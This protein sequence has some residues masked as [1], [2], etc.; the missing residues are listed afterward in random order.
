[1]STP[2]IVHH[3]LDCRAR[4]LGPRPR[5]VTPLPVTAS[6]S[7]GLGDLDAALAARLRRSP[8]PAGARS[9]FRGWRR[10]RAARPRR[11][12]RPRST[13]VSFG[14]P[15]VSVPVLSTISVSTLGE[16]LQRLGVL[17]QHAGLRAAA[18][19]RHDRH[20]RR[21]PQRAGAGDDQHRDR[22]DDGE[23]HARLG[24]EQRPDDE[25]DDRDQHHGRHEAAR[26]PVG[27]PL[28]RRA[29]SAAPWRPSRRCRAS[30]VSAPTF[31]AR[32]TS[33]PFLLS[34]PPISWSPSRLLDRHRLAGDHRFVDRGAAFEHDAV[35]RNAVARADAQPVAG[36]HL[37]ERHVG[38][39]AV[40]GDAPRGL[41][42]EVEQ[43]AD[44]RAGALARLAAPAPG[45]GRPA[46]R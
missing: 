44:R 27:Q 35:D 11:S 18:G 3:R 23:D 31:S 12:R 45:R 17:D 25:G 2:S 32:M 41:R 43:R 20:R 9:P 30:M 4:R 37:V 5:P 40:G 7:F 10:G 28:D 6:K 39:G 38:L 21:Q 22:R 34:V 15:S 42:R 14:L 1:M 24:P 26:D 19:R 46:R 8:R 29:A 13:S 36:L 16:A 33:V